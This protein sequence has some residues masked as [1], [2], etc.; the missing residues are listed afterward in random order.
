MD[1]KLRNILIAVGIVIVIL[2][3]VPF[4]IPVNQFKPTIESKASAAL[5]RQVQMGNLSLSLFTGSL[6]AE[7]LVVGDDPKFSQ[8]PFLTAKGVRV[9]V[10]MMPLIF[11]RAL[12]ITSVTIK[13]PQVTLLHNPA[14][15]WNYSSIGGAA[16]NTANNQAAQQNNGSSDLSISKLSLENGT[17]IV[18]Y[19][20]NPKRTTY[21]HV[22]V[23]ASDISTRGKF[24]VSVSADLPGG[25]KFKVEGNAGPLDATDAALT[26]VDAKISASSLNLGSTGFIEPNTGLGGLLDLDA[27]LISAQGQAE[28]K[29]NAKLSKALFIQGGSPSSAP[30]VMDF[31][32]KYDLSKQSGALHGTTLKI[33]GA[34]AQISGTY[35]NAGE[36]TIVNVKVEGQSMPAKDL[37][38]FLP[39]IG[40][41]LPNGASIESG[42][43]SENLNMAGP[44]TN[45]VTSGNAGIFSVKLAGFDLG[46]KMSSISALTGLKSGKDLDIEKMTSNLRMTR[47]GL[48]ADNFIAVLPAFGQIVGAG[49]VD[50]K[51]NLD[52]KM[53]ATLQNG[54]ANVANPTG[55]LTKVMGGGSGGSG[56]CKSGVTVPFKIE[57]TTADPKFVPDVGGVAAG[58]LKSQ[59]GCA[60][61]SVSGLK[62][63]NP[64]NVNPADATKSLGGLFKK[65]KP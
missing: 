24:P 4:L 30:L 9:G 15:Q 16:A 40:I 29:G 23:E 43:L 45:L 56:G 27:S 17:I 20:G 49:T 38:A 62:N 18:G 58:M 48:R 33:G 47:D 12:N 32:T 22:K 54:I 59:L 31:D 5:G 8:T 37:A 57:G 26:P 42:T 19:V 21:D 13:D 6:S 3:I 34:T 51:N 36:N 44:T 28:T 11:S 65:P 60:G 39:A 46:S 25:G 52:F 41:H 55:A 14:G 35:N 10:A 63:L 64:T 50:A 61:S 2:V 7:N 1:R 53:A